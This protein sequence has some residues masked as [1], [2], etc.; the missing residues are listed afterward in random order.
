MMIMAA[1]PRRGK[2]Q[3]SQLLLLLAAGLVTAAVRAGEDGASR[4]DLAT[5]LDQLTTRVHIVGETTATAT[6]AERMAEY[7][8]PGV[9]IALLEN[10]EIV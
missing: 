5:Q 10:G 3:G 7:R 2:W 8:V 9:S 4:I 6:L 1:W